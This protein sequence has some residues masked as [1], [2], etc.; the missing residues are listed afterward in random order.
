MIEDESD[1]FLGAKNIFLGPKS[2][3]THKKRTYPIFSLGRGDTSLEL[4]DG[5]LEWG[6][7]ALKWWDPTK[8]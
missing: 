2:R 1:A 5:L 4:I 3:I 7:L 6:S 8:L